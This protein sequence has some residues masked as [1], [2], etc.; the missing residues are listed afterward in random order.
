MANDQRNVLVNEL[1]RKS[2]EL[3]EK[4]IR[5]ICRSPIKWAVLFSFEERAIGY[6]STGY[7][8]A[9]EWKGGG[10]KEKSGEG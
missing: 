7:F 10:W 9:E 2:D 6:L 8:E 5:E 4:L 1:V 3:Q